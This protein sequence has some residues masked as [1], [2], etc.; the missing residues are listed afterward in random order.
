MEACKDFF[1]DLATEYSFMIDTSGK[2]C[3]RLCYLAHHSN[4]IVHTDTPAIAWDR[5]AWIT[6]ER[7][8][9]E[10]FDEAAK[11]PFTGKVDITALDDIDHH[12]LDY[13]E[14]LSVV[15]ACKVAGFT[16]Q[17]ADAWSR[18][19]GHRYSEGEVETRWHGLNLDVSWGAVVNLAKQN[20]YT[21]PARTKAKLH[22]TPHTTPE[23]TETLDANRANRDTATDTFLKDTDT[24]D[25]DTLQLLLVKD[26]TGTGKSHTLFAKAQ[27]H[28]KRTLTQIP[29]SDLATQAVENRISTRV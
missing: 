24:A 14:W 19:G 12:S 1:D 2:D 5:D 3:S 21:P 6:A 28:G 20:G 18:K 4:A 15:T 25:T 7:E 9:Q 13:N 29:H 17:Q 10:A 8:R 16:W 22:R 26:T 11:K 23:P 27:Q